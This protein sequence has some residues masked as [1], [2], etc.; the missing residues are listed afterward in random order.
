M[1]YFFY[2]FYWKKYFD[3]HF[4]HCYRNLFYYSQN[5][6]TKKSYNN[7]EI[8]LHVWALNLPFF[9]IFYQG[10]R[11]PSCPGA[12]TNSAL[13][14]FVL[15]PPEKLQKMFKGQKIRQ[16]TKDGNLFSMVSPSEYIHDLNIPRCKK[17]IMFIDLLSGHFFFV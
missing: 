9:K 4:F 15:C 2:F 5:V 13:L 8:S 7:V 11:G 14:S 17:K 12:E 16:R 10:Y 1:T 3:S 6:Y